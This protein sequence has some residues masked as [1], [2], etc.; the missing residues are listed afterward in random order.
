M[1][2]TC[3]EMSEFW[4]SIFDILN[5]AFGLDLQP[6]PLTAIF[7]AKEGDYVMSSSKEGVI[8][9]ATLIGCCR[10]L[11]EWKSVTPPKASVWLSDRYI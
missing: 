9:F 1:F 5:Q 7:G 3:S 2:W 4:T 10:I 6:N 8:A 11:M